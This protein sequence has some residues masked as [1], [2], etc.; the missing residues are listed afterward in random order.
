M[1]FVE[2]VCQ[3]STLRM[4]ISTAVTLVTVRSHPTMSVKVGVANGQS[5]DMGGG[6]GQC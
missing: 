3:P 2:S 5:Y 1:S 4:L 6:S